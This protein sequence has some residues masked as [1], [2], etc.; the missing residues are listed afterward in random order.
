MVFPL[1]MPFNSKPV[2][3]LSNGGGIQSM[4][5]MVLPNSDAGIDPFGFMNS[6]VGV[7]PQGF[8]SSGAMSFQGYG[9]PG[10]NTMSFAWPGYPSNMN[11]QC[12]PPSPPPQGGRSS[13]SGGLSMLSNLLDFMKGIFS[14]MM[15]SKMSDKVFS[16]QV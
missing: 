4:G 12:M 16:G 14:G 15:Y 3:S 6:P 5:E 9:S 13:Q 10:V 8:P 1:N 7:A 11:P 2:D